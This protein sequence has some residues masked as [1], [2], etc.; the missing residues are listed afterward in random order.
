MLACLGDPGKLTYKK[1]RHDDA[2][3]DRAAQH[4]L[5]HAGAHAILEFSPWGYDERQF[6]SPGINLPMGRLTRSP[7][8]GY[9]E[10]HTSADNLDLVKPE[11][12]AD[13]LARCLQIFDILEGNVC[14]RNTSPKGDPQLG[15][16]GLYRKM[17]GFQDIPERQWAILWLLN[18]ATGEPKLLDIAER[19]GL[20]F[21]LVRAAAD[22]LLRCGLLAPRSEPPLRG[23]RSKPAESA[24]VVKKVRARSPRPRR[25]IRTR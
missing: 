10:Y 16:R 25:K 23:R 9:P 21:S 11:A 20:E 13:S 22:D 8:G 14:Y 15:R 2:E 5:R 1:S 17:G 12:L 18:L 7:N 4:V 6:G 19:A 3:I 24:K